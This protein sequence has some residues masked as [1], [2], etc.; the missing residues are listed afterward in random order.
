MMVVFVSHVACTG[1]MKDDY[2]ILI[3]KPQRRK[4]S[5]DLSIDVR[6]VL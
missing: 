3:R 4:H 1:E 2:I 6:K 5:E